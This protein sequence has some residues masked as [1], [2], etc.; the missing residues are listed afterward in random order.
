MCRGAG[1]CTVWNQIAQ[2]Q[3]RALSL[4]SCLIFGEF[5]YL[6]VPQFPHL[7]SASVCRWGELLYLSVPQ[8]PYLLSGVLI[9]TTSYDLYEDTLSQCMKHL[10]LCVAHRK[11]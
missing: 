3:I 6:S 7:L 9:E 5:L 11:H 1:K 2:P 10:G 4:A 8:F